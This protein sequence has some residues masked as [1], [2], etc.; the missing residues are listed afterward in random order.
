VFAYQA[1]NSAANDVR[2]TIMA[3]SPREARDKLRA[4]GLVVETVVP[5]AD[6]AKRQFRLRARP[7][8]HAAK[9]S[10]AIRDL[11]TLLATGEGGSVD[12]LI[13][14]SVKG[15]EL[16]LEEAATMTGGA[17]PDE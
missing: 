5:Q 16:T 17:P 8:R 11:A 13:G 6:A 12:A 14:A 2:G 10:S 7:G 1:M 15:T 9:L 4:Q 3:D